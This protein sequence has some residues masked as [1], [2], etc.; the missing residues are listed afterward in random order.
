MKA[1]GKVGRVGS[2]A[3][4]FGGAEWRGQVWRSEG[5]D[6]RRQ[7]RRHSWRVRRGRIF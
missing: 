2:R 4:G 5:R 1:T 3:V 7:V 6:E